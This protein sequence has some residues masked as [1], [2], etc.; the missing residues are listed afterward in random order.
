MA[1]SVYAAPARETLGGAGIVKIPVN[2]STR[3]GSLPKAGSLAGCRVDFLSFK[4]FTYKM[5]IL[6]LKRPGIQAGGGG[7]NIAETWSPR[8]WHH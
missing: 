4:A 3:I 7:G 6:W 8:K 1:E 2:T 5:V